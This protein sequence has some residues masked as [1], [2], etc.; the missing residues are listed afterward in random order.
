MISNIVFDLGNVLLNFKPK[1]YLA[2]NFSDADLV[3]ELYQQIFCSAEWLELDRGTLSIEEV[4]RII[5]QRHPENLKAIEKVLFN[6]EELLTPIESSVEILCELKEKGYKIYALSNFHLKA[7]HEV[8]ERYDF[9]KLFNGKV[10][11]SKIKLLKPEPEIYQY[12]INE[13][14]IEPEETIFID[15]SKENI[16]AAK[17]FGIKTIHFTASTDLKKELEKY[18]IAGMV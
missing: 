17:K 11:S 14:G 8:S 4:I 9:F 15:D 1:E 10:I 5:G 3:E 6:W 2:D 18:N 13:H 12:L 7:F 16:E